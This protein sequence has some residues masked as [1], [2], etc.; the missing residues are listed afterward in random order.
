MPLSESIKD[1]WRLTKPR[2]WGLLVFTGAIAMLVAFKVTPGAALSPGLLATGVGAL[3]LGSASAEVLTNYHDRDID[4][5]MKRTMKRAIPSGWIKPRSALVFGLAMAVPS[6]LVPLFLI[7]SVSAGFMLL[8]LV[9]NIVGYSL[10]LKRRSWLNIV[11]GGISGCMRV[12]VGYTAVAGAVT[13]LA[14]YMSALVIVWIPTH[15][16][17]LAYFNR[18]VYEAA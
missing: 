15:S 4:G 16:W 3:V 10:L 1:Y 2:I 6:V 7:N 9:D 14:L 18:L 8:G 11:L 12:L 5:M 13:P 17:S